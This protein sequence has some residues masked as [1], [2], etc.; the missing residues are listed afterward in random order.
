MALTVFLHFKTDVHHNGRYVEF[1]P[2]ECKARHEREAVEAHRSPRLRIGYFAMCSLKRIVSADSLDRGVR[3][4]APVKTFLGVVYAFADQLVRVRG[5]GMICCDMRDL[6][7][8]QVS[9]RSRR[10][11]LYA[12]CETNLARGVESTRTRS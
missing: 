8:I 7:R 6:G 4:S 12:P 5:R 1:P 9:E 10:S 2:R 3:R 11:R